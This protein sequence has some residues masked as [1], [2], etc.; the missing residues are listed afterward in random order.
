MSLC[1]NID[2]D[3]GAENEG[4]VVVVYRHSFE[5]CPD[6]ILVKLLDLSLLRF[7]ESLE[8][9]YVTPN[10]CVVGVFQKEG[11]LLSTEHIHLLK[12]LCIVLF[13]VCPPQQLGESKRFLRKQTIKQTGISHAL[14]NFSFDCLQRGHFQSSGRSSKATPSCSA[15]S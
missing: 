8:L 1:G 14:L 6:K 4:K 15:G 9:S 12:G 13:G 7:Q 11:L 10:I 3:A 2:L 5:Q